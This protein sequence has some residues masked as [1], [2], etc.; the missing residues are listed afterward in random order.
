VCISIQF[1]NAILKTFHTQRKKVRCI[2]VQF[3]TNT[4]STGHIISGP[5]LTKILFEIIFIFRI[6][7]QRGRL[8]THVE[9]RA[10]LQVRCPYSRPVLTKYKDGPT[11]SNTKFHVLLTVHLSIFILVINQLDAQNF[12]FTISLFHAFTYF[13]HHVLIIRRTKFYYTLLKI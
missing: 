3:P 5:F 13:E 10:E 1:A 8:D 11:N 6:H 4:Q 12:C 7:I 2:A 9:M